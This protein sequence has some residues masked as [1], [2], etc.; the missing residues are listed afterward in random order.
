MLLLY[1]NATR[2]TRKVVPNFVQFWGWEGGTIGIKKYKKWAVEGSKSHFF[3]KINVGPD[4]YYFYD[5]L[6]K[7]VKE[8]CEN[9]Q[10][11][12]DN[13]CPIAQLLRAKLKKKV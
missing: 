13:L 4:L 1:Q 3:L 2:D 12:Q 11:K 5:T 6:F 8:I 10:K 9:V 7:P